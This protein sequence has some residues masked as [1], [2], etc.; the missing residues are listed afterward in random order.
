MYLIIRNLSVLD[1]LRLGLWVLGLRKETTVMVR[2][3][4]GTFK[5]G[6]TS[7]LYHLLTLLRALDMGLDILL[8]TQDIKFKLDGD[9]FSAPRNDLGFQFLDSILSLH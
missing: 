4:I 5:L 3:S 1:V 6:E 8:G 7:N 9:E 2:D